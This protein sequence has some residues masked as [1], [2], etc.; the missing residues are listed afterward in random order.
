MPRPIHFEIQAE[1]TERAMTFYTQ[2]FGWQFAQWGQE[3]YWLVT[4]GEKSQP[5]IDGGLLPRQGGAP[6]PMASVNAFVCTVDVANL[7]A[8]VEKVQS[9]GG[10]VVL[11]KMAIATVGWLAYAKDTEGNIFGMMQMDAKAA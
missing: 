7:D 1:D 3:K 5:G 4:T 9:L 8:M 6:L 10:A 2:L 11:P